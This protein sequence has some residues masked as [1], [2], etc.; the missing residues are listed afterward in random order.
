MFNGEPPWAYERCDADCFG[1]NE[2][3]TGC[4]IDQ[5]KGP[6]LVELFERYATGTESQSSLAEWLNDL[7]YRTKGKRRAE[8]FGELIEVDGRQFTPW[9]IRDI[10]GNPFYIAKVRYKEE[11][12]D[13]RLQAL[14][15][16]DLFDRAQ[17][18]RQKNRSRR[19][20]PSNRKSKN[21]HLLAKLFRCWEC[22]TAFWSQNQGSMAETYY[23]SPNK[24][25]EQHC[26]YRG[27]SFLGRA[28][29]SEIDQLLSGFELREDW[30]VE[31]HIKGSD[32][33]AAL[34][35]KRSIES[36]MKRARRLYKAGHADWKE[37][38]ID[39]EEAKSALLRLYIPE[40]DG[41]VEAGNMLRDFGSPWKFSSVARRNGMARAMLEAVY[42][43]PEEKKVV[44][45][46]PKEMFLAPI[47]AMAARSEVAVFDG[48]NKCSGRNGG[49][50]GE[51]NSP[52]RRA[53]K[54]DVL[55]ACPP[56][57]S[58]PLQAP[59]AHPGEAQPVKSLAALTGVWL[60]ASRTYGA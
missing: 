1:I 6:H 54:P 22:G 56:V 43:N 47:L 2:E 21:H 46:V 20:T 23:R 37:Y 32:I 13:G 24:G 16:Q 10:L 25:M 57:C 11:L 49:D 34:K 52:S 35:E 15:S 14:I 19:S 38:Q 8:V 39:R 29:D 48:S 58:W 40:Y 33:Q 59:P 28:F 55:Q 60:A 3:H 45:L 30:I 12:F 18:Q 26:I 42:V 53:Y 27:R 17:A 36:K 4:H 5:D 51:S 44:G 50:G 41:A 31:Q 9:S 7:G